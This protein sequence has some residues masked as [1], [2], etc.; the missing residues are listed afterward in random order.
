MACEGVQFSKK[1]HGSVIGVKS[2]HLTLWL[3]TF[4][5]QS[6]RDWIGFD[7][8]V[9]LRRHSPIRRKVRRSLAAICFPSPRSSTWLN[10]WR[11]GPFRRVQPNAFDPPGIFRLLFAIFCPDQAIGFLH[12]AAF[13]SLVDDIIAGSF[14]VRQSKT[15]L[16]HRKLD[17]RRGDPCAV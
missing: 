1:T 12:A 4:W 13:V 9:A 6:N 7:E 15:I 8:S 17:R 10:S 5:R 11:T 16:A 3:S 14:A 2:K